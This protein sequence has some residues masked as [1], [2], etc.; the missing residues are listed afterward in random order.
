MFR[1]KFI[2]VRDRNFILC[3]GIDILEGKSDKI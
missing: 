1:E 2:K 3:Q